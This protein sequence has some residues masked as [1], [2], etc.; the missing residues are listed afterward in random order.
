MTYSYLV[1]KVRRRRQRESASSGRGEEPD[2]QGEFVTEMDEEV[3]CQ[4]SFMKVPSQSTVDDAICQFIDHT[5]N[6]ALAMGVCAV[7]A[8]ETNR[9]DLTKEKLESIPSSHRLQ[10]DVPHPH[11][12]IINGMLLH[13]SGTS[14][15]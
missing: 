4:N 7:C 14:Q 10:P 3:L 5:S 9:A 2:N 12:N 8:R 15:G 1:Q 13:P 6:E 11:H